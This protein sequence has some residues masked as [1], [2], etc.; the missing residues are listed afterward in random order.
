MENIIAAINKLNLDENLLSK[1]RNKI[2]SVNKDE[3]EEIS[4][5][6]DKENLLE[7]IDKSFNNEDSEDNIVY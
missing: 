2:N 1:E 6:E 3:F 5:D 4:L 7:I